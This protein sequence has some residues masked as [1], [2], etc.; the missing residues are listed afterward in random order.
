MD[1]EKQTAKSPRDTRPLER[2]RF[3]VRG[4]CKPLTLFG[5]HA[6]FFALRVEEED[7]GVRFSDV[8]QFQAC[9]PKPPSPSPSRSLP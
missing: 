8:L 7:A 2:Y 4:A 3:W 1:A 9:Y 5:P 6:D